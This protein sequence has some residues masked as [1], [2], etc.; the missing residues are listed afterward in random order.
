MGYLLA[1]PAF[2]YLRRRLDYREYGAAPLLGVEGGCFIG[3]GR[4]NP[5]AVRSAIRRAVEFCEANLDDRI[6][7]KVAD[8]HAQEERL[9]SLESSQELAL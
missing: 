4:S 6:R 8:L 3:H 1:K 5:K 7:H 2:E 9:E